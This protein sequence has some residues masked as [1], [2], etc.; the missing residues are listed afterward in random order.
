M[1]RRPL[2]WQIFLP[3]VMV[4]LA[5]IVAVTWFVMRSTHQFFLSEQ[6]QELESRAVIFRA[7]LPTANLE[8]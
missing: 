1:R 7:Q 4:T 5:A 3:F 8:A 6:A 2:F